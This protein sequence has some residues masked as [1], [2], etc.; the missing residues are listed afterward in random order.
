[1]MSVRSIV[2]LLKYL[3]NV[4][5]SSFISEAEWKNIASAAD[6]FRLEASDIFWLEIE[7]NQTTVTPDVSLCLNRKTIEN[8]TIWNRESN[9]YSN[10]SQEIHK[11]DVFFQNVLTQDKAGTIDHIWVELD[12]HLLGAKIFA[13]LIYMGM[14]SNPIPLSATDE[15]QV[16]MKIINSSNP[17]SDGRLKK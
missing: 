10:S 16:V 13:P 14:Y 9:Y 12:N 3:E 8:N 4:T 17:L 1:M 11:Y 2:E 15:L 5:D 6:L 7:L